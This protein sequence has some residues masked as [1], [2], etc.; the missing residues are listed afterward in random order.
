MVNE[1][2]IGKK[3]SRKN[4]GMA[5][6]ELE[7]VEKDYGFWFKNTLLR[8]RTS[9]ILNCHAAIRKLKYSLEQ[10]TEFILNTLRTETKSLTLEAQK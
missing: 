2:D 6:P 8:F 3:K 5:R 4:L 10:N 9:T 7:A 1:K